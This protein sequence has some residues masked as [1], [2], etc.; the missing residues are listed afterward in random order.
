MQEFYAGQQPGIIGSIVQEV[1]SSLQ[2]S[3]DYRGWLRK[4]EVLSSVSFVVDAGNATVTNVTYDPDERHVYF[5]LNGGTLG[6]Q[7]NVI[8]NANTS[9]GQSRFDHIGVCVETN[10]GAVVPSGAT[11]V[12]LSIVGPTGP[13]G[14]SGA[15]GSAGGP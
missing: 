15:G 8:A 3:I 6:T 5:F 13:A 14:P 10:G 4:G 12:M 2:Y 9:I 11:A 1:S 7:F